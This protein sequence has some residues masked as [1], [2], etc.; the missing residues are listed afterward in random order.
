M[1]KSNTIGISRL[2]MVIAI[3]IDL[4]D[5]IFLFF[6]YPC[7]KRLGLIVLPL[8]SFCHSVILSFFSFCSLSPRTRYTFSNEV[9]YRIHHDNIQVKLSFGFGCN[10]VR[11]SCTLAKDF[12]NFKQFIVFVDIISVIYGHFDLKFRM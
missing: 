9:W 7:H 6:L 4:L 2:G 10:C 3:Y 11:P 12:E 1:Q 8:P 5:S